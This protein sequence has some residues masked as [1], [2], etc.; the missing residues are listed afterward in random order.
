MSQYC[1]NNGV[2]DTTGQM[3]P[4]DKWQ[5]WR[6]RLCIKWPKWLKQATFLY[7]H[8]H[9]TLLGFLLTTPF[10]MDFQCWHSTWSFEISLRS[11]FISMESSILSVESC[12]SLLPKLWPCS[13]WNLLSSLSLISSCCLLQQNDTYMYYAAY[14]LMSNVCRL[15][16]MCSATLLAIFWDA[17]QQQTA[18]ILVNNAE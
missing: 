3:L 11:L 10:A 8:T 16:C 12:L 1:M 5:F 17:L 14:S 9:M 7:L 15:K 2:W 18:V 13:S 6:K 4:K